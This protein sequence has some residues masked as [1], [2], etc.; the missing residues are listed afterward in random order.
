MSRRFVDAGDGSCGLAVL[1]DGLLEYELVDDGRELALTVLRATGYLSRSEPSLRPNP[2]GPLDP[3]HGSQMFGPVVAEYALLPHRG[4]WTAAGLHEAA[5]ELLVPLERAWG[6]GRDDA[7]R[8]THGGALR[9]D[10]VPVSAVHRDPTGYLVVRVSNPFPE[11]RE[12]VIG[13]PAGP[14]TGWVVDLRGGPIEPFAGA[15]ELRPHEILTV[16]I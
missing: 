4:D 2:A 13:T 12:V 7:P 16:R 11:E 10:G 3:L 8:P 1:H 9:V 6:G 15:R 5:D 14:A